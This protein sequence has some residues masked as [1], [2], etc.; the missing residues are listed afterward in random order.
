MQI[1]NFKYSFLFSL[2]LCLLFVSCDRRTHTEKKVVEA[3]NKDYRSVTIINNLTEKLIKEC[4][5]MT[6]SGVM[7]KHIDKQTTDNIV[8]NNVDKNSDFKNETKFK[9]ILIDRYGLKYEKTF[10]A[11][12]KGNTNVVINE[13]NFVKQSFF[14]DLKR[15]IEKAIN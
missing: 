14:K 4:T 9:I 5:L 8:F 13:S 11:S 3:R 12:T 7:V 15:K 2:I 6:E 1:T 10:I